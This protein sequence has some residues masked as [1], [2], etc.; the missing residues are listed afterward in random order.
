MR[1]WFKKK[2]LRFK[3]WTIGILIALGLIA[4][5]II[6]MGGV[7]DFSWTN[8]TQNTDDS[9]FNPAT[10]QRETRLYCTDTSDGSQ[11]P[12]IVVPGAANA[13]TEG[14]PTGEYQC[15]GTVVSNEGAESFPSNTVTFTIDPL[16]P[17]P[18]V[19][20]P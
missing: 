7:K 13:H 4:V 14:F 6:G 3:K 1:D 8:P 15:Y 17:K 19:L 9:V 11:V 2:W 16:I 5:P 10:D 20:N 12:V 18:P